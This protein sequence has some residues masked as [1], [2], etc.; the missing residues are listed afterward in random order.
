MHAIAV[1][2]LFA[3]LVHIA[4]CSALVVHRGLA[5]TPCHYSDV[6]K[7]LYADGEPA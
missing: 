3:T 5:A 2:L 6:K 1:Q 7:L 4:L